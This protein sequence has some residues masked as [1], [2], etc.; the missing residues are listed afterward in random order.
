MAEISSTPEPFDCK[1][2]PNEIDEI[3]PT[4]EPFVFTLDPQNVE[5]ALEYIN[6]HNLNPA[7][8]SFGET[9]AQ[10]FIEVRAEIYEAKILEEPLD[11]VKIE[12]KLS[13]LE[14]HKKYRT[15][16]TS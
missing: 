9:F 10:T 11:A 5:E 15:C 13:N 16:C 8:A 12:Q 6:E 7:V 1:T 2:P 3:I 14:Y 4:L